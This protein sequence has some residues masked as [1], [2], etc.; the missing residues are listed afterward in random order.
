MNAQK[1]FSD[2]NHGPFYVYCTATRSFDAYHSHN[3]KEQIH[4]IFSTFFTN[5]NRLPTFIQNRKFKNLVIL[6]FTSDNLQEV[7]TVNYPN[8]NIA[9]ITIPFFYIYLEKG[10]LQVNPYMIDLMSLIF[11]DGTI[12]KK[13]MKD[14]LH[15]QEMYF[16]YK[17]VLVVFENF[18]WSNIQLLFKTLNISV[19][20]GSN[21]KRHLL[22]TNE[23]LLTNHLIRM[24]YNYQ[25]I[26]YSKKLEALTSHQGKMELTQESYRTEGVSQLVA[27]RLI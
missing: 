26:W 22:S 2:L 20:G 12:S 24:E 17:N 14:S 1:N 13:F 16:S 10:G 7:Q 5:E 25:D 19:S 3:S 6:Y 15:L 23:Y 21:S 18:N 9:V 4:L 11:G 27:G 8:L